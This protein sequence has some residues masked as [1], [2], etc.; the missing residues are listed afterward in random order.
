MTTILERPENRRLQ[1]IAES[2]GA[3][4][5]D[6]IVNPA[7]D[8]LPFSVSDYQPDLVAKKGDHGFLVGLR[9]S[10]ARISVDRLHEVA[11]EVADHSGWRFLLVTPEDVG[12]ATFPGIDSVQATWPDVAA[13]VDEAERLR[14]TGQDVAAYL[15]LWIAFERMLRLRAEDTDAPIERLSPSILIRHLY[16][17]GELTIDQFDTAI[18]CQNMRNLVVHGMSGSDLEDPLQRLGQL[19]REL[20]TAW[21]PSA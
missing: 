10:A 13:G 19:V 2:Y 4:G 14:N 20:M 9:S 1:E 12:G 7:P 21:R 15:I 11:K 17:N 6:V 18:T 8:Q 16:S 5:Y 3:A